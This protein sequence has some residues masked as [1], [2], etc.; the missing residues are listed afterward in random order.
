MRQEINKAVYKGVSNWKA[1]PLVIL[2]GRCMLERHTASVFW[3]YFNRTCQRVISSNQI[4][5]YLYR[6]MLDIMKR[7]T[8]NFFFRELAIAFGGHELSPER[9]VDTLQKKAVTFLKENESIDSTLGR[10]VWGQAI[11]FFNNLETNIE[12]Q[13]FIEE[14]KDQW[15]RM[16]LEEWEEKLIDGDTLDWHRLMDM[17]L[18]RF[19]I[20]CTEILLNPDKQ[21]PFERFF[22]LRSIPW[23]QKLHP[24]IDR[25][26]GQELSRYSPDEITHIVR[27]KM[28][29]DLQMVRINGSFVGGRAG[30][31][32]PRPYGIFQG[33]GDR[34]MIHY[35]RS[36]TLKQRANGIFA[37]TALLYCCVFVGQFFYDGES[38]YQPLYWAV[39]SA[40]I[41][42]VADWFAVTALFRKPLGF[43]YHTALIPRNKERLIN[44]VIQLVKTKMLTKDRCLVLVGNIQFVPLFEQ[45]LLSPEGRGRLGSSYIKGCTCCGNLNL[46]RN[47]PHGGANRIRI[48]LRKQSL[49][50]AL[51][52]VLLDLCEHNRYESMVVQVLG[53][54]QE[55]MN[56]PAMGTWLTSVVAEEAHRKKRKGF[57]QDFFISVSEAT[58]VINYKEMAEAIIQEV[59]AML[60]TWKRPN[61]PERTAWLRQWVTPIRN[62]EDNREVCAALDEAWER[63]IREQDWESIIEIICVLILRNCSS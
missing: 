35:I 15:V 62:I 60:E 51:K 17:V 53:V 22:L 55:R 45:F 61:S 29:Y 37:L 58:D 20:L 13:A 43:P 48:L 32:I 2:F 16:I 30:R 3:L 14:H 40:L 26:V 47:G 49:V 12:W 57:F 11:R 10:Y 31:R 27:G 44:G 52:H 28:Y 25:V 63:W 1:T 38:W 33:G 23:L 7:Y 19:N 34:M 50:P 6:V 5:P 18:E 4:Y 24:L 21:A 36:L 8:K 42:S 46:P 41:G 59:Y 54:V 9:L 39:Q 56:H